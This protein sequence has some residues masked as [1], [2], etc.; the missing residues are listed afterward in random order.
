MD[1]LD[2]LARSVPLPLPAKRRERGAHPGA[3]P[4]GAARHRRAALLPAQRHRDARAALAG[5]PEG[6]RCASHRADRPGRP[7]RGAAPAARRPLRRAGPSCTASRVRRRS[8]APQAEVAAVDGVC[9][10]LARDVLERGGGLRRG[11]RLLP[12]LRP[13][14]LLR[15]ARAGPALRG[16]ERALR[17]PRRGHADGENAPVAPAEDLAQRQAALARFAEKWAAPA[18]LRRAAAGRARCAIGSARSGRYDAAHDPLRE[19]PRARQRLHRD[20]RRGSAVARSRRA[21]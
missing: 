12:R 19:G 15:G 17:A 2:R 21:R 14:S 10:F 6:L 16:G 8:A 1:Y 7:L 20:Q 5:A 11:L 3:Q 18:A 4:G 9:L 13:R